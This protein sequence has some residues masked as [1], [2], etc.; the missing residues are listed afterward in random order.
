M[1]VNDS[2]AGNSHLRCLLRKA[3]REEQGARNGKLKEINFS[4]WAEEDESKKELGV[5]GGRGRKRPGW[6]SLRDV[7]R[8]KF[9]RGHRAG[10][11]VIQAQ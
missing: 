2:Q 8:A 1:S 10:R 7:N 5:R 3:H 11:G 9:H 6:T 4:R